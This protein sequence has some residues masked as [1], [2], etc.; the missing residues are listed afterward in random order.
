MTSDI[1]S[2]HHGGVGTTLSDLNELGKKSI[3]LGKKIDFSN[4]D[5]IFQE[6]FVNAKKQFLQLESDWCKIM[7][8]YLRYTLRF[9]HFAI[10]EIYKKRYGI[11]VLN[12]SISL[13]VLFAK[14]GERKGATSNFIK[15]FSLFAKDIDSRDKIESEL[16]KFYDTRNAIMHGRLNEAIVKFLNLRRVKDYIQRVITQ[17]LSLELY[18]KTQLFNYL[19]GLQ[20]LIN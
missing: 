3:L 5:L 12:L 19:E 20:R 18:S 15:R 11:S 16:W 6:P 7:D 14:K 17:V 9:Y 10:Q 1:T 4:V 2:T 8:D 13:E